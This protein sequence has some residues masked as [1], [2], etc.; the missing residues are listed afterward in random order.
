MTMMRKEKQSYSV[1]IKYEKANKVNHTKH[2]YN[3]GVNCVSKCGKRKQSK[4]SGCCDQRFRRNI[5]LLLVEKK[6]EYSSNNVFFK[7]SLVIDDT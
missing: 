5:F 2:S 6:S 1:Y 7:N 3:F 4:N